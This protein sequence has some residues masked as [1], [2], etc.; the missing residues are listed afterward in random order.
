MTR[1]K[2]NYAR[3]EAITELL[4]AEGILSREQVDSIID[5]RDFGELHN[6]SRESR[7]GNGPPSFASD[8]GNG[9]GNGGGE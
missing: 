4:V 7:R 9:N 1:D 6:K 2:E 3:I 5:S 8:G